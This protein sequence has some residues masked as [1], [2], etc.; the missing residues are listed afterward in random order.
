MAYKELWHTRNYGIACVCVCLLQTCH[1]S[2][3]TCI[4]LSSLVYIQY[5]ANIVIINMLPVVVI[6]VPDGS[7]AILAIISHV[8]AALFKSVPQ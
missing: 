7:G 4:R 2:Y 3:G 1:I 8:D 6:V 5:R